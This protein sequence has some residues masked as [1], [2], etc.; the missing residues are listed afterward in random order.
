MMKAAFAHWDHRIA[1]V[2]DI[3]RRLHVAEAESGRIVVETEE[4]LEDGMPVRKALR[5]A[6]LGVGTLVCGAISRPLQKIVAAYGVHVIPF[7]AGDLGEVIQAWLRGGLEGDD[8][9]MPGCCGR[10][11]LSR[12]SLFDINRKEYLMKG[13]RRGG[14]G[15]G[16]GQGQGR[17]GQ[18]RGRMGGPFAAGPS[19]FCV[20]LRCGQ[21]E[22]HELGVPCI[23]KR[24]PKCGTV[25]TRE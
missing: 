11:R 13:R 7:V 2:F 1:P 22:P 10:D 23:K 18:G 21:R 24:C 4:V 6:E 16:D 15:P 3:A 20:C 9:A 19:G 14:V 8:F 25:M 5:L 12:R 17:G